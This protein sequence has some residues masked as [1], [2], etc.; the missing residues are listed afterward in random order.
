[1]ENYRR[2][3]EDG[4]KGLYDYLYVSFISDN[5]GDEGINRFAEEMLRVGAANR[6]CKVFQNHIIYQTITPG[7]FNLLN[8]RN[9]FKSL[10]RGHAIDQVAEHIATGLFSLFESIEMVPIVRLP[11]GNEF[12]NKVSHI[13]Y[14]KYSKRIGGS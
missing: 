6:V 11:P 2:I 8:G 13:L 14:Q 7:F 12:T 4:M 5:G 1:M 9:N 3:A 10:Q